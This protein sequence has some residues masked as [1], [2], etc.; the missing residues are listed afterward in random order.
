MFK[1][2]FLSAAI[3]SAF[4]APPAQASWGC[5]VLLC[6]S[7]PAGPMAVSACV[8]PIQRLYRA[9]F[10][11]RPQPF[12]TC[13]MS[14]GLDSSTGGNY[15]RIGAPSY[16][17]ACPVNTTALEVG[18][19]AAYGVPT[20]TNNWMQQGNFRITSAVSAGIGDGSGLTQGYGDESGAMPTKTCVGNLLGTVRR[21]TG[22]GQDRETT[23]VGIYDNIVFIPPAPSTFNIDVF[24]NNT[25]YTNVRPG[26]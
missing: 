6:L 3:C 4:A 23:T 26:F 24:V 12:P 11:W 5:E 7:N 10:R 14:S 18:S 2:V 20:T 25:L 9:I 1:R 19:N 22:W 13:T 16:Y 8:P 21:T 15:A 17:D